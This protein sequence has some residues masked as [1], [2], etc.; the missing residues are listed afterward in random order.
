MTAHGP[1]GTIRIPL[2]PLRPHGTRH[3]RRNNGVFWILGSGA[4][5]ILIGG[6]GIGTFLAPPLR[7]TVIRAEGA[8]ETIRARAEVLAHAF[9]QSRAVLLGQPRLFLVQRGALA[10]NLRSELTT[11]ANVLVVRELPGTLLLR[12]QEKVPVA[13]LDLGGHRYTL[14][15]NGVVIAD[16]GTDTLPDGLPLIRDQA[17]TSTVRLG[18]TVVSPRVLDALHRVVVELPERLSVSVT[19][20]LLPAIGVEELHVR[21]SGDWT[22]LLDVLRPLDDQLRAFEQ[23]VAETLS[24]DELARL[25]SVDL[26]IPGKVYYRV[27]PRTRND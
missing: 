14:D 20:I 3:P 1:P 24:A 16:V 8:T 7:V 2:P 5:L 15:G 18:D 9:V 10:D 11:I 25:Q 4:I 19:E 12:L 13:L 26:R 22:L 17:K 6:V 27:R 21:T 23:M